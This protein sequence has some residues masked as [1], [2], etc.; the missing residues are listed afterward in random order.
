LNDTTRKSPLGTIFLTIF[1]D[2]VGFSI[3]FPLFPEML[4]FYMATE[5]TEGLFGRLIDSLRRASGSDANVAALF[6]GVLGSLYSILQFLFAP[7]WG[8]LSDRIG[9]RPVLLVTVGGLALSYLLWFLSGSFA[10]LV[11]ARL[12]GGA[13]AGNIS[14]ATAAV[15]DSTTQENRAKGMGL[16]GAAFGLG[17]ILGPPLGALLGGW[18]L[19]GL[20]PGLEALGVNPFSGAAAGAFI[21]SAANLALLWRRFPETLRP[22]ERGR[23]REERRTINPVELFRP[24]RLPGV[25]RANLAWFVYLIAFSGMEFT[26]TFLAAE[27]FGYTAR[28]IAYM[29]I[30]IGLILIFVQ[31]GMI[32]Q[33]APVYGEKA[34]A[35]AGLAA[36]IP[37]LVL[38]GLAGRQGALYL[39]LGLM[40][41]GSAFVMPSLSALVSLY[42]PPDRQGRVIGVFRSLGA[43]ARAIGPLAAS[44]VYFRHGSTAPYLAGAAALVIP[45]ALAAGLPKPVKG[46]R[47]AG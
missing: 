29:F 32:R 42:T 41:L 34:L 37:G 28:Q 11:A 18:N 30:Y 9:R 21:L 39:G 10:L 1:L 25:T 20:A 8:G 47:A 43:L 44:L 6:G 5:G 31:G 46:A 35:I 13:M 15:A 3:I 27:R 17:F 2:L 23:A 12:F 14:V 16:V 33:L 38:T 24:A 45:L 4:R 40:A 19:P 36:V 22:E 26:L 7:F